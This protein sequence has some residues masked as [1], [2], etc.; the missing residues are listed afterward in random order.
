VDCFNM[1]IQQNPRYV[2]ALFAKGMQL[3]K[4]G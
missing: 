2:K 1:A 4:V 3:H